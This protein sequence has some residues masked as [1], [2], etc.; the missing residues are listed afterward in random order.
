M[1]EKLMNEKRCDWNTKEKKED[2][3]EKTEK[4]E[5]CGSDW[6]RAAAEETQRA[7]YMHECTKFNKRKF[8][9]LNR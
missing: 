1:Y 7:K 3:P 8:V 4:S 6:W 9:C 5:A 2:W